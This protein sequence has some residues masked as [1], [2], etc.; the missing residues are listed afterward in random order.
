MQPGDALGTIL[1]G[2]T[3]HRRL[4]FSPSAATR[5]RL[6]LKCRTTLNKVYAFKCVGR[7]VAPLLQLVAPPAHGG[8]RRGRH[9]AR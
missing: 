3:L 2:E 4:I 9:R 8:D 5:H 6:A 7:G 1:P